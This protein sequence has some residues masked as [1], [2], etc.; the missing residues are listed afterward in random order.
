MGR[1]TNPVFGVSWKDAKQYVRWLSR[2]TGKRYRLLSES[3]W[4]YVA[5]AGTATR[6]WWGAQERV[7]YE[8]WGG[9]SWQVKESLGTHFRHPNLFGL[10]DIHGSMGEWV[11]DCSHDNYNGAPADGSAWTRTRG[12]DCSNRVTRDNQ[13]LSYGDPVRSAARTRWTSRD[14]RYYSV[15]FRVARTLD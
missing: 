10:H 14:D 7:G 6:Y 3:E 8:Y 4:E 13:E 5:R 2:K 9:A 15:G 1:R 11:E 12:G